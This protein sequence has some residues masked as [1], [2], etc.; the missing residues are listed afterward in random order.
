MTTETTQGTCSR[1]GATGFDCDSINLTQ[2]DGSPSE[3]ICH[4]C[5]NKDTSEM[6][7][8]PFEKMY[9]ETLT[10]K[11]ASNKPHDFHIRRQIFPNGISFK[12]LEVKDNEFIT[13][14]QFAVHGDVNCNQNELYEEL[15]TKVQQGVSKQYLTTEDGNT[16]IKDMDAVG[17]FEYSEY[18]EGP[19][20]VIDGKLYDWETF[21][22]ICNS[23]EGWK[24]RLHIYDA[25]EGE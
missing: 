20:V 17:H 6:L 18:D 9:F 12:A 19:K 23:F 3:T 5:W 24:F 1:C 25:S 14:Y 7:G 13:G 21:G 4:N 10:I 15:V 16:R 22:R 8:I 2:S 11:D